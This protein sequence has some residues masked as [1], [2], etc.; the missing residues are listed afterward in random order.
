MNRKAL[1]WPVAF[2]CALTAHGLGLASMTLT[3]EPVAAPVE[4]ESEHEI[5]LAPK[6]R[7]DGVLAEPGEPEA[8]KETPKPVPERSKPT[9]PT[10]L[11]PPPA[12]TP[13]RVEPA[14]SPAG[15]APESAAP[16]PVA[17]PSSASVS[18]PSSSSSTSSEPSGS[19]AP[20]SEKKG[21][22]SAA[23][24][25]IPNGV[26]KSQAQYA[27]LLQAWFLKYKRYP[28]PARSRRQQGVVNIWFRVDANG[29]VLEKRIET[30]SGYRILDKATLDLL[31]R[32]S[33]VPAPP[34]PLHATE[35]TFTVPISYSLN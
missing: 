26:E 20:S 34:A 25:G 21:A 23:P 27:G 14:R 30:G 11:P 28:H 22:A 32:A 24:F 18:S 8:I 33:P 6:G 19:S 15:P 35:L 29:N 3:S 17:A 4:V 2:A 9:P 5:M 10:P 13:P 7:L 31:D 12:P 1:I 16:S